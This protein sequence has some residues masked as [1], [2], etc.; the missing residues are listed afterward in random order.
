MGDTSAP[1]RILYLHT[2]S[3]VGGSDV[4]LLRLVEGLDRRK[5]F[6]IVLLPSDGPL[7]ARLREAGADVS[8]LPA[9]WKLTSRRGRAFLALFALHYPLAVR[10]LTR[11]IRRERV[12]LVHTNTI[13]NL[14]GGAAAARARVPHVW[15]IREIV[16]Q[17]EALKRIE[18]SLVRRWSTRIIVTSD[19]VAAMFDAPPGPPPQLVK[20]PN[21]V[22]TDRFRPGDGSRVR[23]E[24]GVAPDQTLVGI[25]CRLDAWK[26]VDVFLDAAAD[27]A[28]AR[29][30]ARF[31]VVGGPIIGLESYGAAL[32]ARAV[33][34]GIDGLV[35]FTDWR[36]AP[37]AMP[38]VYRALDMLVLASTE[39]EPFGLTV[40]E[41]MSTG[42]PVIATRHGGPVELVLD[43]VTGWL[44][45]PCDPLALA[46]AMERLIDDP[47]AGRRMGDA[48]RHRAVEHY[49]VRRCVDGIQ[50]V[51]GEIL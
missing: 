28:R 23:G 34:L 46:R 19:A 1:A 20:V 10:E 12:A 6:P 9:L 21:G 38:D 26:G 39:P 11:F 8:V 32:K 40:I 36:Y 17:S 14:Y 31:A 35:R 24:L 2:T 33:A 41:A 18:L 51:Y 43:G 50:R 37:D 42:K 4:S 45:P 3:E 29:P 48:G 49:D 22:D 25:V 47:E 30:S 13:H 16:W 27:V 5:F 44:V 15:H 7:V